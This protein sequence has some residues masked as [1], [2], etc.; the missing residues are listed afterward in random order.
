MA[1]ADDPDPVPVETGNYP[2][3]VDGPQEGLSQAP[4]LL[5]D[6]GQLAAAIQAAE[7]G[8]ED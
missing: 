1:Q 8:A 5:A 3:P 6:P 2:L 4:R 7:T